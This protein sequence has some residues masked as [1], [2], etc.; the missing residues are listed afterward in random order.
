MNPIHVINVS[1]GKDSTALLIHAVHN[2]G[3]DVV[4]VFADTGN[5]HHFTL[6]YLDYLETFFGP[7]RR[8]KADLSAS[9]SHVRRALVLGKWLGEGIGDDRIESA[10]C[11]LHPTGIPFLDLCLMKGRFPSA[12]ARF[13]SGALKTTPI[14]QQ[15][16]DPLLCAGHFVVSWH[17]VRAGESAARAKLPPL[18]F[19]DPAEDFAIY[20]PLLPWSDADVFALHERHGIQPNPLYRCGMKRV[21]CMPCIFAGKMELRRIGMRFPDEIDRIASWEKHVSRASK[22]GCA[23]FFHSSK[24]PGPHQ[25]DHSLPMPDIHA[26]IEWSKTSYGGI[27]PASCSDESFSISGCTS[28]YGLCE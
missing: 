6:E 2:C 22:R 24:T 20:R 14:R 26:V 9:F 10:L 7:I 3:F 12:N 17:G 11:A 19:P 25:R 4:P 8:I 5:E 28:V 21:G 15:I 16:I 23:A 1:G 13:C 18:E 27:K